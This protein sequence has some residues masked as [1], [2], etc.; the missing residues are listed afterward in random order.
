MFPATSS[1]LASANVTEVEISAKL[2][3]IEYRIILE[4]FTTCKA[5][6]PLRGME[7]QEK[8]GQED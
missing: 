4:V 1:L 8:V 2:L 7:L 3:Q 6:Q 5:K